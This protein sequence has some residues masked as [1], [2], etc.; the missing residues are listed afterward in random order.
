M[1]YF[2]RKVFFP[3]RF[4]TNVRNFEIWMPT[5]S[6]HSFGFKNWLSCPIYVSFSSVMLCGKNFVWGKAS[7]SQYKFIFHS[8][9]KVWSKETEDFKT[10]KKIMHLIVTVLFKI[11]FREHS[12]G[13]PV[14]KE[15]SIVQY[16]LCDGGHNFSSNKLVF[17]FLNCVI[18][19]YMLCTLL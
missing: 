9:R 13:I 2:S 6:Q 12:N 4:W 5:F 1:K 7:K 14:Y 16:I 18:F 11:W 10:V 15:V 19:S 17:F 3:L 8:I